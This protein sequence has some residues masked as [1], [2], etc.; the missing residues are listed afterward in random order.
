MGILQ[1]IRCKTQ[2]AREKRQEASKSW[3]A[4]NQILWK[5]W[6]SNQAM[7]IA[8][9]DVI[10]AER[11]EDQDAKDKANEAFAE[12]KAAL[13]AAWGRIS[14][15]DDEWKTTWQTLGSMVEAEVEKE[16]QV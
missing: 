4:V 14:D 16:K 5:I 13:T 8:W 1:D 11:R 15:I 2:E 6:R 12:A 9:E 7:M 3:L 10:E